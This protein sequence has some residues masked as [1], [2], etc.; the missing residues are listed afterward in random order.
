MDNYGFCRKCGNVKENKMNPLCDECNEYYKEEF[1]LIR[2]FVR[3]YGDASAL[4]ISK[5][6]NIPVDH[7]MQFVRDGL[8]KVKGS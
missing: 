2:K 1:T 7:I 3:Q 5:G 8:I 4:E 6:T